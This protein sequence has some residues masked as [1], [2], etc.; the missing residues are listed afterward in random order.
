ML[1]EVLEKWGGYEVDA[2][3]V[4]RDIFRLGDGE[5]QLAGTY[6]D[7]KGNPIGY[8]RNDADP[9]GHFRVLL[10]PEANFAETLR[11]MQEA[12]FA[13]LNGLSYFGRVNRLAS[14]SKCY[15]LIFDLDGVTDKTLNAF[16]SGAIAAD[17]YPV[18]N[19]IALSG[20]GVHL[21]FVMDE[22][23]RLFPFVRTQLKRMKY[24]LTYG[25]WNRYTSTD[26]NI[27]YQTINQGF[28]PIGGK[29]KIPGV[30]VRAFRLN[31]HPFS[32]D[33][34]N[35]YV[36]ETARVNARQ[37]YKESKMTL[38]EAKAKYPEWYKRM[39]EGIKRNE[40]ER[41]PN[42]VALYEWWKR[43]IMSATKY[44]HRYFCVMAL[45][46][47]GIKCKVPF[48]QVKKDAY[49]LIPFMNDVAPDD[50]FTKKDVRAALRAYREGSVTY[51]REDIEKLTAIPIPPQKRNHRKQAVH[52]RIAR[53]ILQ[54]INDEQGISRQGRKPK[55]DMVH[56]WRQDHPEGRKADCIRQT[57]LDRKTVSKWW[58]DKNE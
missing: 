6:R 51:P 20:H 4:Y 47:F 36:P 31:E 10:E 14:A 29:T 7:L 55:A 11:E 58:N 40:D 48:E 49:D 52:L 17:A 23:V 30:R 44:G 27:Q 41:E 39:Q 37:I 8:W 2:M 33:Q 38:E 21:Y 22:P 9:K 43:Q 53:S 16:L 24:A 1:S 57:G 18:P 46:V 45:A 42:K 15:A 50:P 25:M 19:Y 5:I 32:L 13:I 54:I 56:A 34:L 35:E 3:T 28:R 12:D 26:R